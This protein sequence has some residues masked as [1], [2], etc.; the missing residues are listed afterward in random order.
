MID[1]TRLVRPYNRS[2][3]VEYAHKWAFGRNPKYFSFDKLGGDCT[4]F[5]SQVLFAGSNVMNYTPTY[6]WYYIDSNRRTASWTG[7]NFLYNFLV[8]NKG[9]GPYAQESDVRDIE[10]GDIIQLSFG[11]APNFDHS[12]VVVQV[13]S[14]V[15]LQNILIAAHTYDRDYYPITK[16]NWVDIRF[17]HILGVRT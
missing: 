5:A 10:P 16:Y 15:S 13:G 3:A 7:V 9:S 8:N 4:N 17:I 2:R 11:G 12:P 1:G 14:P 6:G